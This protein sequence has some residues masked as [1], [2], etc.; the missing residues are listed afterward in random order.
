MENFTEKRD[1]ITGKEGRKVG[2]RMMTFQIQWL[3]HEQVLKEVSCFAPK[4]TAVFLKIPLGP[5]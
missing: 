1:F 4:I 5:Y 2:Y 3:L